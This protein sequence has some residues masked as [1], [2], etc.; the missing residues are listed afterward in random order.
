MHPEDSVHAGLYQEE[1][2]EISQNLVDRHL[3]EVSKS[4]AAYIFAIFWPRC[5]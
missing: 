1:A 5:W 2:R 3:E 4:C